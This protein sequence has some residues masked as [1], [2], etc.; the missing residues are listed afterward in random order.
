MRANPGDWLL[1]ESATLNRQCRRG[2]IEDISGTDGAPPYRVRWADDDHVSVV[3]P[4]PDA[5]VLT[6]GELADL[7][8]AQ[9]ARFGT[10]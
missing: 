2:R 7:D 3:V 10:P 6:A 4:G 1:I 9:A 5:H 8:R